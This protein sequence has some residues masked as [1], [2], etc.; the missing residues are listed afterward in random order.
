MAKFFIDRPVFAWVISIIIMLAGVLSVA[1]LPVAQYPDVAPPSVSV[2]ANYP[3][4]AAQTVQDT[5]VQ[6]IEQ[7]LTGI[8]NVQYMSSTSDSSGSGEVSIT[9]LAGTDP[10]IAQVQVQNKLQ[11]TMPLLPQEVQQ[12]G[13]RVSKS[14]AGFLMVIGLVSA[15]GKLDK[16]DIADYAAAN[17]QDQLS[18]INGVGQI[19]LFGSQY[20]M[21]IW[22]D[23]AKLASYRLTTIDITSAIRAQNAQ[24]AAGELGGTPA[25]P[26]QQINSSIVVQTRLSTP[27]EFGN[28]LLRVNQ[29]GSQVRLSDVA[30]IELGGENYQFETEYN[31]QAAAGMAITLASGA[32][33]LDTA[34]AV[35][36]RIGE[37]QEY[38]PAGLEVVY[39]FD[40]T[41]FVKLSIESVVHTLVEAVILVFCVM[42]LF[43]QNF[44]ATLIP[45]IAVPVVLLGTFAVLSAF[46]FS[47]NTLTMF[48]MVLAIGLLV[49]DA[50]V[51]VENV[52]RVM[53]EEGLSP[54]DAT[55]KSMGQI[56]SAL[57]GI[58]LVL[59]A[60]FVP[61]AFFGGSTGVIYRQFSIT[62]VSAMLLSVVVALTLTPALCATLLKPVKQDHYE[63]KGFFGWFNRNFN[64]ATNRY[65]S[66]VGN[67]LG[68][69]GRYMVVY[70]AIVLVL[71]FL[72]T[73]LPTSFLPDEDQ[74]IMFT[75]MTLPVGAT[76][77]RSMAVMDQ[78]EK[79]YLEN[80]GDAVRSVFSVIGFSFSGRGQNN[81]IAFVGLKDWSERTDKSLHV[82]QLAGRAMGAFSQI[83]DAM[84]FPFVP[85]AITQLGTSSG[86]NLQLQDLSGLGHDALMSARD[87]FLQLAAQDNRLVGVRP[88]GQ[89]DNPQY[90]LDIDQEKAIALGVS[91]TDV[92]S[93]FGTAWAS[94]YVN[95]FIDKG[96]VK[97]V[98]VQGEAKD[99]MLPEDVSNW[100]VRNNQG[101]MVPFS[102][103]TSGRW[104]FGSPRLER[105]N[106]V[107]SLNILGQGAS[108]ISSGDAMLAAEEIVAQLPRGIGFQ[109]SGMSFQERESGNQAPLLYTLSILIVFL[110]LAALYES[111]SVPFAVMLVVPL[112]VLGAVM[113]ALGRGLSNDV[114]FQVGLLTTI[115]LAAKNAIL[116]VEFAKTLYEEG[117]S[118]IDATMQAVRMRLRP[119]IMTSLAF[120]LGVTPLVIS[121]GAGSG[122]QNAIGTGVFGGMLSATVLAIFFVPVF[123]VVVFR[124]AASFSKKPDSVAH[125][126]DL[127]SEK[128]E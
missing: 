22:L 122:S 6:I 61:M 27:E 9:F 107:P 37:L 30:R 91:L 125:T 63:K 113:F 11:T 52:E 75:Q 20:A 40:T 62:I 68:K 65:Q 108:G 100:Y 1:E 94:S 115:G 71:G 121:T 70:L 112:G 25:L 119:I 101:E 13:I 74:G 117:M 17:I 5:V 78:V 12:Q 109:W 48:A 73:R 33:A 32:N 103:F 7:G 39:P 57:I 4:A 89:N 35:R 99:R 114:Y 36:K 102:A 127:G 124:L 126:Q 95:D 16:Y 116:I 43:L 60:V 66:A 128:N 110:C 26:G 87:Q 15:D 55:R 90:K 47:I 83:R 80:E 76:K 104:I 38:F 21:R 51:V 28:I 31:N 72:F 23:A 44:R 118:L 19:T 79:Y 8:D 98:F 64:A 106:G 46:G 67:M 58:A 92:S 10:D 45:T 93:I 123:F 2:R 120:M 77:E 41:P 29:D 24:I 86:F 50:I 81:G 49:D 105:Y 96:R 53:A 111:W 59:S 97:K 85:P 88:N 56:T 34:D 3:G 42:Y 82:Q 18:R 69:S 84:V 54:R 14:T